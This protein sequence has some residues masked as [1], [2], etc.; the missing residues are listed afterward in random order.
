MAAVAIEKWRPK[1]GPADLDAIPVYGF[2]R[3]PKASARRKR[4]HFPLP[5]RVYREWKGHR[6]ER[7]TTYTQR[8]I[9]EFLS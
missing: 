7:G 1:M 3:K 9:A 5:I 2:S 8:E 6:P 4:C